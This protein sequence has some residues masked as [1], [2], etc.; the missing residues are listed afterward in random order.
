MRLT[1][2][3]AQEVLVDKEAIKRCYLTEEVIDIAY[4]LAEVA[5]KVK[6]ENPH[7]IF[8]GGSIGS[9]WDYWVERCPDIDSLSSRQFGTACNLA[10]YICNNI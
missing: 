7:F 9:P 4:K 6:E 10:A 8:A 1:I 3:Q 5:L 2:E